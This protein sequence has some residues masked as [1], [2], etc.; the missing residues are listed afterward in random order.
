M[1]IVSKMEV[2]SRIK[3]TLST[4]IIIKIKME[5]NMLNIAIKEMRKISSMIFSIRII[6]VMNNHNK[7]KKIIQNIAN[8][9]LINNKISKESRKMH[10]NNICTNSKKNNVIS[11][12]KK[13]EILS[14]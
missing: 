7:V 9:I 6:K 1:E 12:K 14:K 13:K 11:T 2:S 10:G 5:M 4:A 3:G 8:I